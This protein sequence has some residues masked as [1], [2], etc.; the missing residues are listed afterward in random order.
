MR[1]LL[2]LALLFLLSGKCGMLWC[3]EPSAKVS[4]KALQMNIWM[5]GTRVE[6]AVGMIAD[7]II[8]SGADVV[9]LNELGDYEGENFILYMVKELNRRGYA[10]Y[11]KK[12][13]LSIGVLARFPIEDQQV[14]YPRNKEEYRAILRASF[15]VAGRKVAAYS[16]HLDYQHYACYLPRGYNGSTWKKMDAPIVDE[17][18]ILEMNRIAYREEAIALFLQY[19]KSDIDNNHAVLLAGDFNEPSHLDWQADTKDLWDHNGAVVNWDCSRMLYEGGFKDAYRDI[20]PNPVTNPGFTFPAGNNAVTI[21]KLA[22]APE[23]DERDRIDFIYYYPSSFLKA[24]KAWV[25]G[26]AYS[27]VRN[28]IEK[29]TGRDR[30]LLPLGGWPTDHKAVMVSFELKGAN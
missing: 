9:F 19:V 24:E 23:S 18:K 29:E 16:A 7:E 28:K 2:L 5:G 4:L 6:G 10:F 1:K 22:W 14:I 3:N 26:P 15:T 12:T 25:V 30:F 8:H 13:P 20:Y 11:G 27:V 21:D 17:A